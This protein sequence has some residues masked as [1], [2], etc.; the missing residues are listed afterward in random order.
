MSI[1]ARTT[2]AGH[3]RETLREPSSEHGVQVAAGERF[4]FGKNWQRFLTVVD[5]E[6]IHNAEISLTRMLEVPDLRGKRF[7]DVGSGSGL[8]SLA[9]RRLGADVHSFDYDPDAVRCAREIRARFFG[10]DD[11]WT[12][13]EG[14]ALDR[15]YVEALGRFDVVYAWGVLHHS[16]DMWRALENVVLPV[17]EGGVLFLALYN[18][19]GIRS[20]LWRWVKQS[21]CSG[22]LGRVAATSLFFPYFALQGLAADLLRLRNPVRRYTSYRSRR[23]MSVVHDWIDWLGGYPFEVAKP[24]EVVAYFRRRGFV[25][26]KVATT[27]R[28]GNNQFVLRRS[29]VP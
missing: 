3:G 23:G 21:Y 5:E 27:R 22:P 15:E 20:T 7:L 26:E 14:S 29:A 28:L 18:D 8:F 16:G 12:I 2:E 13:E 1:S 17:A 10:G 24:T 19:Q 9:A 4:E 11:R 25:P 6:R